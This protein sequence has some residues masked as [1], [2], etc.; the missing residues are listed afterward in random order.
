ME[1]PTS[2]TRRDEFTPHPLEPGIVR[3]L[4]VRRRT[5]ALRDDFL[6]GLQRRLHAGDLEQAGQREFGRAQ[7]RLAMPDEQ[8]L[9][10]QVRRQ[11]ADGLGYAVVE[12]PLGAVIARGRRQQV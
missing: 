4:T 3:V 7:L 9:L 8:P 12:V 11:S 6:E 1:L 5:F 2:T 10:P